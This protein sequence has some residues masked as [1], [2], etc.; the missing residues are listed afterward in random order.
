MLLI[1]KHRICHTHCNTF[2]SLGPLF[3]QRPLFVEHDT[4]T[5]QINFVAHN[6]YMPGGI[7]TGA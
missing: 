3:K 4:A 5:L 1:L 6:F 2:L 7:E